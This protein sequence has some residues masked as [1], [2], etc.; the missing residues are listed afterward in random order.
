MGAE[1]KRNLDPKIRLNHRVVEPRLQAR[2]TP[3][4]SKSSAPEPGGHGHGLPIKRHYSRRHAM[5]SLMF[6]L[7]M[8]AVFT[9]LAVQFTSRIQSTLNGTK[10]TPSENV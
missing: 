9:P 8:G 10:G 4:A 7:T 1:G 5:L 2:L 3:P 6:W